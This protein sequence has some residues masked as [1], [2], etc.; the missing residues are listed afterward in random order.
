MPESNSLRLSVVIPAKNE[1]V[2]VAAV[3]AGVRE[4]LESGGLNRQSEIL[5]V[6][7]GSSDDTAVL[8]AQA[9]ARVLA[10][11]NVGGYGAALKRGI[12]AAGGAAVCMLDADATYPATAILPLLE[13][14]EAG[15]DQVIGARIGQRGT[16]GWLRSLVKGA[17]RALAAAFVRVPIPDLNSGMR[18]LARTRLMEVLHL[19]PNGFSLTT[20]LTVAG[21]L[22]GWRVEWVEIPYRARATRSKFR[23]WR[24]SLRLLGSLLRG[25]VYFAPLRI[26]LPLAAGL[27]VAALGFAVWDVV[28]EKNLTDKTVLLSLASLELVMLGLLA[29]LVVRRG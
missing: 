16:D 28:W 25:V 11:S 18:C 17:I 20:S 21:L 24:D 6:D 15:A 1:A 29:E 12:R 9:G 5:V 4:V 23:P 27:G 19:L 10:G 2:S 26:F 22:S 3:V 8:A 14:V 13:R 7:D